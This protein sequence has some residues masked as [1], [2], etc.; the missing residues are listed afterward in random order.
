MRGRLHYQNQRAASGPGWNRRKYGGKE[1]GDEEADA[2]SHG[3]QASLAA[4]SNTGARFDECCDGR[5]SQKR[6]NGY[7]ECIST[8]S[9]CRAWE[10]PGFW[11]YNSREA[12]HAVQG[13]RAVDDIN[14]EKGE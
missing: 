7:T 11:I 13:G 8:V 5:A 9:K 14:I 10:I 1:H 2:A 12:S 3:R 6:A 4:F